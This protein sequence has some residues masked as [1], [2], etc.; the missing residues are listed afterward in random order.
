[1]HS[2]ER[3]FAERSIRKFVVETV[4]T[5]TVPVTHFYSAITIVGLLCHATAAWSTNGHALHGIGPA[6]QALGGAGAAYA[7]DTA[8]ALNWNPATM[9]GLRSRRLD[10]SAE[11]FI[12]EREV[13]SRISA[14][15]FGAGVPATDLEGT[16]QSD[17]NIAVLPAI[18]GLYRPP[19]SKTTFATSVTALAGFG[20]EYDAEDPPGPG[21]NPIVSSQPPGGFGFGRILSDYQLITLNVGIGHQL[22]PR[23]SVGFAAVA[24][25]GRLK[26]KPAP[27][28]APDDANGDTFASYPSTNGFDEAFG[29]GFR[30]GVLFVPVKDL[31]IGLAYS[32]PIW[33]EEFEWSTEDEIGASRSINFGLDFP[34]EINFGISYAFSGATRVETDLRW[35][36]YANTQGFRRNG[37]GPTG[38]VRGFGWESI[39]VFAVGLEHRIAKS[40]ILRA[41]YNYGENPIPGNRTFYNV[42]AP[43][44][45]EHHLSVGVASRLS[46]SIELNLTYY[47]GFENGSSGRI[48]SPTGPVPGTRVNSRLSEHS[49]N[50]GLTIHFG[51][52]S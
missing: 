40:T 30:I 47:H 41:G 29:G 45:I 21:S 17:S 27:F 34:A 18:A 37:F 14:N 25:M 3:L 6:N 20:V 42:S 36:D 50:A 48:V 4:E 32:S 15:S 22:T 13:E 26:T 2:Q 38:A 39:L 11:L 16:T 10:I 19:G 49:I 8:S 12:P 46:E 1:M 7:V 44:I 28:A 9:T 43:A 24:A 51:Q 23:W 5:K 33:F 35:I 52:E 31:Q